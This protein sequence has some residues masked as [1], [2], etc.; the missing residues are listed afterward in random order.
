MENK[1]VKMMKLNLQLILKDKLKNKLKKKQKVNNPS[2]L[3]LP[4]LTFNMDH[5]TKIIL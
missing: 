3:G 2:Q 4:F 1:K 5:E